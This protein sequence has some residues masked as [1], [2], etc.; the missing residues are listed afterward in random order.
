M[1]EIVSRGKGFVVSKPYN[2]NKIW[3]GVRKMFEEVWRG[4]GQ[5]PGDSIRVVGKE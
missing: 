3:D 2:H 5:I 1:V 4:E